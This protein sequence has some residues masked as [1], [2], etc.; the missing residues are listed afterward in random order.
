MSR[1]GRDTMLY[2][3]GTI[4]TRVVSFIMLPVYTRY[5]TPADYGLLQ[6]LDL[7]LDIATILISAGAT[8]G[9]MRFYF[10]A[11]SEKERSNVLFTGW[12]TQVGLNVIG[13]AA[14]RLVNV[15]RKRFCAEGAMKRF[16]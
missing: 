9:I 8:A 6:I 5:L 15:G 3:L 2:G 7:A 11:Q 16:V 4:L 12:G 10:K 1:L 14:L 13:S